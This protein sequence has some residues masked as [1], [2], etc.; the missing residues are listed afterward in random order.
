M[1]RLDGK[2]IL[3]TGGTQGVGEA[4]ALHAARNGA[5]GVVVCGRQEDKGR[6]VVA[7]IKELG[8]E[9][10][11]IG[12]VGPAEID[13]VDADSM[14]PQAVGDVL[15]KCAQSA[16]GRA[17]R[18]DNVEAAIRSNREDIN[19]RPRDV[20][21]LHD[22]DAFLRQTKRRP[23][24]DRELVV[25]E[26]D[27]GVLQRPAICVGRRVDQTVNT[28][29]SF[30]T[31]SNHVSKGAGVRRRDPAEDTVHVK[32]TAAEGKSQ[33]EIAREDDTLPCL[34]SLP[35]LLRNRPIRG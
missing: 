25:P 14:L 35:P 23:Y 24:V 20:L 1:S 11:F 29:E 28:T 30:V 15:R 27:G 8:C 3:T 16:L 18:D 22:P 33:R 21:P 10:V 2:V 31:A 7:R 6:A 5:A 32:V 13:A 26:L 9:G 34:S 4:A 12:R 19:D 17:V